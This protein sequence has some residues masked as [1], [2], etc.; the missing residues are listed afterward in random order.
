MRSVLIEPC[1]VEDT[2]QLGRY[3]ACVH[4]VKRTAEGEDVVTHIYMDRSFEDKVRAQ[5]YA[6]QLLTSMCDGLTGGAVHVPG[7]IHELAILGSP[8]PR[9]TKGLH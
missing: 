7:L 5:Q 8:K 2:A 3:F 9:S 6:H 4:V 1:V